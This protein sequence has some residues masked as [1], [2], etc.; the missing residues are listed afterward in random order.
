MLAGDSDTRVS[1]SAIQLLH[2]L[3]RQF[4]DDSL[5]V[6]N[7][8]NLHHFSS[9]QIEICRLLAKTYPKITMSVFS[10]IFLTQI[11]EALKLV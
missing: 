9:N 6:R 10:G 3:R 2:L 4:L 5:T 8:T 1:E 11:L 7:L